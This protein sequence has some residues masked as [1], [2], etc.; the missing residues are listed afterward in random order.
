MAYV[1]EAIVASLNVNASNVDFG[2]VDRAFDLLHAFRKN[3]DD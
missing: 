1:L 2:V 3:L